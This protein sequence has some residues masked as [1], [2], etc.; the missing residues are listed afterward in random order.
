MSQA[1]GD[2]PGDPST[3]GSATH[4]AAQG[5]GKPLLPFLPHVRRRPGSLE[6]TATLGKLEG[7]RDRGRTLMRWTDCMKEAI[8]TSL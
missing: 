4:C 5:N 7:S 8:G 3:R 2:D 1:F 6:K